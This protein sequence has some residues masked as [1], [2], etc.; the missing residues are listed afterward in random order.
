MARSLSRVRSS[1]SQES[2]LPAGYTDTEIVL[3]ILNDT[4]T[5]PP[6]IA[7]VE[8][9]NTNAENPLVLN[10]SFSGSCALLLCTTLGGHSNHHLQQF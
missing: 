8:M 7:V 10:F 5:P 9:N 1:G 6:S 4:I 3:D 2:R